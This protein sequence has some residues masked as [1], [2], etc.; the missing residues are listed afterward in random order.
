M[1]ATAVHNRNKDPFPGPTANILTEND[2]YAELGTIEKEKQR[3]LSKKTENKYYKGSD[4]E[5]LGEVVV[6]ERTNKYRRGTQPSK[7]SLNKIEPRQKT[8]G[9]AEDENIKESYDDVVNKNK[10]QVFKPAPKGDLLNFD[11]EEFEEVKYDKRERRERSR[12][13]GGDASDE[14][15][16]EIR[17]KRNSSILRLNKKKVQELQES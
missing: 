5:D 13:R 12:S 17:K 8:K 16:R 11:K 15:S 7:E 1:V 6:K 9:F 10:Q 2:S 14:E 4:D 3:T